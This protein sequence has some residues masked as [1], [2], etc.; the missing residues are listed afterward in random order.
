MTDLMQ[1]TLTAPSGVDMALV[2]GEADEMLHLMEEAF[3][4]RI[5]VRG[6]TVALAGDPIEVQQLTALLTDLFRMVAQGD[7]PDADS[8]RRSIELLRQAEY[9]PAALRDDVLL[10]YRGRAIRP[11]T[12]GQKAY[13]DAIRENT[14]TFAVGPAGTGKTYLAMAMAVAALKRKE[15]GRIVLSRPIVEAGENLGFLPGTL[16]E[17]VD[18]YIRPLYDA[19]YSM[20][21]M[22]KASSLIEA[23]VIEIAPLAFMRGR[24]LNDAFIILD[25]AQNTTPEQMKMALTRLGFGSKIVV[26]G[27]ISQIDLPRGTSGLVQVRSVLEGIDDI[28]FCDLTGK[29]VVRHSLV[30]TIVA[31]YERAAGKA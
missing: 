20:F 16:F 21:D 31:A 2:V 4:A 3:G 25:E 29:D 30:A 12:A 17:K 10:T 9:A 7:A 8:V 23:G 19:L 6:D 26:T 24:T 14:V 15:V 1:T 5:T 27:D 18:P 22:E 13:V 28:A 11:K